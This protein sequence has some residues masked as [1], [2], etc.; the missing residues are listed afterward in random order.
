LENLA[1][2]D[3]DISS[4]QSNFIMVQKREN[5]S[6]SNDESGLFYLLS[7]T[8]SVKLP[9]FEKTFGQMTIF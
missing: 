4:R 6:D 2:G 9:F 3:E 1:E 8:F 7:K 5:L